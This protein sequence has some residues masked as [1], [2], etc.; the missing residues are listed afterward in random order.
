MFQPWTFQPHL[1]LGFRISRLKS[2]GLRSPGLKLWVENSGVGMSC[3]R[4]NSVTCLM[5][6]LNCTEAPRDHFPMGSKAMVLMYALCCC[7]T[8]IACTILY[9]T[10][11]FGL[12]NIHGHLQSEQLSFANVQNFYRYVPFYHHRDRLFQEAMFFIT[13]YGLPGLKIVYLLIFF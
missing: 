4:L 11:S 13:D 2:L 9:F 1:F 7:F 3:N 10:P 5:S 6:F 8:R 12:F